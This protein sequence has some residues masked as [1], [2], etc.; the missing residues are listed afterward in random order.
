[1]SIISQ[2]TSWSHQSSIS[3]WRTSLQRLCL[4]R[5]NSLRIV[6]LGFAK[7][8]RNLGVKR[9]L[10]SLQKRKMSQFPKCAVLQV[11][12][13]RASTS[14]PNWSTKTCVVHKVPH[15]GT[16]KAD[17]WA[18]GCIIYKLFMGH[19]PF[20]AEIEYHV[21]QKITNSEAEFHNDAPSQA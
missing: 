9:V 16:P 8:V 11:S 2:R 14:A 17:L 13:G 6:Q 4:T 15:F 21:F 12:L 5:A 3:N 1:M 10:I 7:C 20:Q 19:T 18:L